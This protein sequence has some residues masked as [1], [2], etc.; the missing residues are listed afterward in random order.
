MLTLEPCMLTLESCMLTLE[1][2]MLTLEPCM[3][4]LEPCM[5]TLEPPSHSSAQTR[6]YFSNSESGNNT[7][8]DVEPVSLSIE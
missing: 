4:T 7:H 8:F 5:L 3:L 2:C 6:S 1:P